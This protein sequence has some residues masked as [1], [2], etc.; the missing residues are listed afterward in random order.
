MIVSPSRKKRKIDCFLQQGMELEA[1]VLQTRGCVGTAGMARLCSS[2][3]SC[4]LGSLLKGQLATHSRG[5]DS[6]KAPP[7]SALL[8]LNPSSGTPGSPVGR[9][10]SWSD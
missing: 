5:A 6:P 9:R 2:L 7:C 3:M 4:L 8:L 1:L 10:Q